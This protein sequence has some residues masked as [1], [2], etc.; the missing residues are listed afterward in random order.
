MDNFNIT[1]NE[2]IINVI[3][4]PNTKWY[5]NAYGNF[6][7]SKYTGIGSSTINIIIQD[8]ISEI[9]GYIE[10]VVNSY[11]CSSNLSFDIN[12]LNNDY[13]IVSP[14]N[15]YF[16]NKDDSIL[17]NVQSSGTWTVNGNNNVLITNIN[18]DGF[19]IISNKE[20]DYITTIEVIN[21]NNQKQIITIRQE[22]EVI[23]D[24][25]TLTVSKIPD[26]NVSASFQI[27]VISKKG[28]NFTS[29]TLSKEGLDNITIQDDNVGTINAYVNDATQSVNGVL[30]ITN[31]CGL[32]KSIDI[33]YD[34]S[35]IK[36]NVFYI[37]YNNNEYNDVYITFDDKTFSWE[38]KNIILPYNKYY[39]FNIVSKDKNQNDVY[40]YVKTYNE[41]VIE[42]DFN[43]TSLTINLLDYTKRDNE[44]IVLE[45]NNNQII[46]LNYNVVDNLI[47]EIN[48]IFELG[49][50]DG[51]KSKEI[52][53]EYNQNGINVFIDSYETPNY[54]PLE[55]NCLSNDS[56]INYTVIP[57]NGSGGTN[58]EV[59]I[60]ASDEI[61]SEL[62]ND[63]IGSVIFQQ[64][65]TYERITI[66]IKHKAIEKE[67][68]KVS[69]EI[70]AVTISP[71]IVDISPCKDQKSDD[72]IVNA[73]VKILEELQDINGNVYGSRYTYEDDV[74]ISNYVQWSNDPSNNIEIRSTNS[75]SYAYSLTANS[76]GNNMRI[77]TFNG[78]IDGQLTIDG[79]VISAN[80]L[81]VTL[82]VNQEAATAGEDYMVSDA[83]VNAFDL[84]GE[85][86]QFDFNGG[87]CNLSAYADL[88]YNQYIYDSCGNRIDN[89][90]K[91]KNEIITEI[92][93]MEIVQINSVSGFT[94]ESPSIIVDKNE[95][96]EYS[97]DFGAVKELWFVSKDS[98]PQ[99]ITLSSLKTYEEKIGIFQANLNIDNFQGS[100]SQLT[101]TQEGQVLKYDF[102]LIE[103]PDWAHVSVIDNESFNVSVDDNIS[104]T[105]RIGVIKFK[106]KDSDKILE[107]T[108]TQADI[109]EIMDFNYLTFRFYWTEEDGK[110]L[111]TATVFVNTGISETDS[112]GNTVNLDDNP[113]G[114]GMSGR[115]NPIIEQY[116]KFGG[117]NTQSGNE[118]VFIDWAQLLTNHYA[119]LPD[120][121]YAD[122]YGNWYNT[123]LQG[124]IIF[125]IAAYKGGEMIQDPNNQYN[126]INVGGE[127]KLTTQQTKYV[128]AAC[129]SN[130]NTGYKEKY[131]YVARLSYNKETFSAEFKII[132]GSSGN[133]CH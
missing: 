131:T 36:D 55:W 84:Y 21:E 97:F 54:S 129:S 126:H 28:N 46:T 75:E 58:N 52:T 83:I 100:S 42:V 11:H 122:L 92:E 9:S 130:Y 118:S 107:Y 6:T 76:Y 88:T 61:L 95:N 115:N 74:N 93:K 109:I 33:I 48:Q 116:L 85:P 57:N 60:T 65:S 59:S 70:T 30:T 103:S 18:K 17:I 71:S 22:V 94:I 43:Q 68:K 26:D 19:T 101:L 111:D 99:T 73:Y 44:Q 112:N 35:I 4:D 20:N 102:E 114:F 66:N 124:N 117:D 132:E 8:S 78:L 69:G 67:W 41:E 31:E 87:I 104:T 123:K 1:I 77:V 110:D 40:W 113:V 23:D 72:I 62:D 127:E 39:V 13:F 50:T 29:Y 27:Y 14:L 45:N 51:N 133:D 25:C 81:N 10:F 32:S 47:E 7:L 37:S 128:Y 79:I 90:F 108:I 64:L 63:Y 86:V 34:A 15:V 5:C 82:T 120:V 24:T 49:L 91:Q 98:I 80:N 56:I 12:N 38:G 125:E 121:I 96:F 16:T 119:E 53:T 3:T 106:Q 89:T 2:Q 105:K